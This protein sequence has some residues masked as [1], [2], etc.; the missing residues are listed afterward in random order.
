MDEE[1][2]PIHQEDNKKVAFLL[3]AQTICIKDLITQASTTV[4]H[5]AK[6]DWL[7]LNGRATLLLFRLGL[8]ILLELGLLGLEIVNVDDALN[9]LGCF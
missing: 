8:E 9:R 7:E 1:G 6:I 2:Q 5:D 3:D 4:S